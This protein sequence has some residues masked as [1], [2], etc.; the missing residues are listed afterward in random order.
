[1]HSRSLLEERYPDIA[2]YLTVQPEEISEAGQFELPH[3]FPGEILY[4]FGTD[5]GEAFQKLLPWLQEK[6]E[7]ALIFLEDNLGR[8]PACLHEDLLIHPQV[9]LKYIPDKKLWNAC[10]EEMAERFPSDNIFCIP[11]KGQRNAQFAKRREKLMRASS[12]LSALYSDVLYSH[13]LFA[14]LH[15]NFPKLLGGFDANKWHNAFSG[16]PAIICGAGPSLTSSFPLLSQNKGLIIAGGSAIPALLHAGIQPHLAMALDPNLE[17]LERLKDLSG[18]KA[19]LLC[20]PRLQKSVLDTFKGAVGYLYSGTGGIAEDWLRQALELSPHS[21]IGDALGRE[22]F[23]VT[24][25]SLA[26]AYF[27][28]CDPIILAGVDLAYTKGK[29]YAP[30][31][32][33]SPEAASASILEKRVRRKDCRGRLVDTLLKWVMEADVLSGFAKQHPDRHYINWS[34]GLPIKG[35]DQGNEELTK[36]FPNLESRIQSLIEETRFGSTSGWESICST[37]EQSLMRCREISDQLE[38]ENSYGKKTKLALDFSEEPAYGCFLE[39]I[40]AALQKILVRYIP[41]AELEREKAKWREL[42]AACARFSEIL[43]TH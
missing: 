29:R 8:L 3:T 39:G 7:R 26:Y 12:A 37:L 1:M 28:G 35:F 32:S 10:L 31:I 15:V 33:A 18:L 40:E 36:S 17:E 41:H 21:A 2:F 9:H 5:R 23:S 20:S 24:T 38:K 4:F 30:G 6:S 27:L 11:L 14:N 19:P 25:L 43:H 42:T 16:V 34:E 13:K 22:A